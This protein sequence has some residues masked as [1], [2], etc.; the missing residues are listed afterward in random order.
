[1]HT[2]HLRLLSMQ[3]WVGRG[4]RA[5]AAIQGPSPEHRVLKTGSELDLWHRAAG[6]HPIRPTR[7]ASLLHQSKIAHRSL[8]SLAR[9]LPFYSSLLPSSSFPSTFISCL[10]PPPPGSSLSSTSS[11]SLSVRVTRPRVARSGRPRRRERVAA[12][13]CSRRSCRNSFGGVGTRIEQGTYSRKEEE[14]LRRH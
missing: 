3:N 7:I 1:M 13:S 11:R 5:D 2:I 14:V 12:A 8:R 6:P 9:P 10:E 4:W